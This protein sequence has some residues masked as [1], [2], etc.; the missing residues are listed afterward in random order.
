MTLNDSSARNSALERVEFQ[1]GMA[2]GRS[3]VVLMADRPR[4]IALPLYLTHAAYSRPTGRAFRCLS[5]L[6]TRPYSR[7]LRSACARSLS[8]KQAFDFPTASITRLSHQGSSARFPK[9]AW[10]L[11][12]L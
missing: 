7:R 8:F 6:R 4:N 5:R 3:L 12:A 9:A 2:T 1:H 10:R 11:H